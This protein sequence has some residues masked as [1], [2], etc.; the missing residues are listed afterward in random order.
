M[1]Q[2]VEKCL[3]VCRFRV[4]VI[5]WRE[6]LNQKQDAEKFISNISLVFFTAGQ[7]DSQGTRIHRGNGVQILS[8]L[9][10]QN[11]ISRRFPFM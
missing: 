1:A 8:G 3:A 2:K 10:N 7:G 4:T 11:T 5:S 6:P 9:E